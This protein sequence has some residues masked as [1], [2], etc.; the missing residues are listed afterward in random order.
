M[1][2][3]NIIYNC[4]VS[5]EEKTQDENNN[6]IWILDSDVGKNLGFTGTYIPISNEILYEGLNPNTYSTIKIEA[7]ETK[8]LYDNG[9]L[10]RMLF[11]KNIGQN[12]VVLDF[13]GNEGSFPIKLEKNDSISLKGSDVTLMNQ[14]W[15]QSALGTEVTFLFLVNSLSK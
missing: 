2:Q 14:V 9:Q 11:V 13:T 1:K 12:S 8:Q 4:N 6:S 15:I 10:L 3:R 5:V 7:N